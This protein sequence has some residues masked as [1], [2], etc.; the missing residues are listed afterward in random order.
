MEQAE[1][2]GNTPQDPLHGRG[3]CRASEGFLITLW[4]EQPKEADGTSKSKNKQKCYG[5][6]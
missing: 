2:A 6:Q 3:G 1:C 5:F 4:E